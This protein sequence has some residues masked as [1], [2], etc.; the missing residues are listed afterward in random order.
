[1]KCFVPVPTKIISHICSGTVTTPGNNGIKGSKELREKGRQ[2]GPEKIGL[3]GS[4]GIHLLLN[5][6]YDEMKIDHVPTDSRIQGSLDKWLCSKG[7]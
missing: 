5:L 7:N 6:E 3:V 1:M 2:V 4:V